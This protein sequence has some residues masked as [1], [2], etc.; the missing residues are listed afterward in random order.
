MSRNKELLTLHKELVLGGMMSEEEFWDTRQPLLALEAA[1]ESQL[2]GMSSTMTS[3]LRPSAGMGGEIKYTLTPSIIHSIFIQYPTLRTAYQEWV[4]PEKMSEKEFWT[5]Y[6]SSKLFNKESSNNAKNPLDAYIVADDAT[7]AANEPSPTPASTAAAAGPIHPLLNVL[8][9][10]EDHPTTLLAFTT[11]DDAKT[12]SL[13]R[14]LNRHSELVLKTNLSSVE[15]PQLP[16]TELK[17]K[18]TIDDLIGIEDLDSSSYRES[19]P[20]SQLELKD[21]TLYLTSLS[22]SC[23]T[24]QSTSLAQPV[25]SARASMTPLP[26]DTLKLKQQLQNAISTTAFMPN[27]SFC[28]IPTIEAYEQFHTLIHKKST[29]H[30]VIQNPGN[31]SENKVYLG[32]LFSISFAFQ[33]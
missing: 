2:K 11:T 6:F 7:L 29:D 24:D 25:L 20:T 28:H 33:T 3:E 19:L 12:M 30:P 17:K 18:M 10:A 21:Q 13:I 9:S 5:L 16:A 15:S 26:L 4:G 1:Q 27:L 22:G 14:K 32:S 23:Q 8:A 31:S